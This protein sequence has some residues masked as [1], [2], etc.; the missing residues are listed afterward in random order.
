MLF[1]VNFDTERTERLTDRVCQEL[2]VSLTPRT[3]R[4]CE[5]RT[6]GL[7]FVRSQ[8]KRNA[9]LR[10]GGP[11]RRVQRAHRAAG[12]ARRCLL[13]VTG[14]AWDPSSELCLDLAAASIWGLSQIPDSSFTEL[15][16]VHGIRAEDPLT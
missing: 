12:E 14:L 11:G 5:S 15:L 1:P 16:E 10:V 3:T 6:R 2:T 4:H 9:D 13:P 8:D 7:H